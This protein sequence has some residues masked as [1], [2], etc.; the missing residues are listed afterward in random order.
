MILFFMVQIL[1]PPVSVPLLTF[2]FICAE[3]RLGK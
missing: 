3:L 2:P 1:E